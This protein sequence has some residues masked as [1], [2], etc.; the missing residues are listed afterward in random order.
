[1][2]R[3][4]NIEIFRDTETMIKENRILTEAVGYSVE[5]QTLVPEYMSVADLVPNLRQNHLKGKAGKGYGIR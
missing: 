3:N 4:E 2:S 1:M 5:H